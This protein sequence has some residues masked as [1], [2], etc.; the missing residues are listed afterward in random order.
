MTPVPTLDSAFVRDALGESLRAFAGPEA[1]EKSI[2]EMA[3]KLE[4][5]AKVLG[6]SFSSR[7]NGPTR[8]MSRPSVGSAAARWRAAAAPSRRPCASPSPVLLGAP[9][10]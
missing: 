2:S 4:S 6:G 3:A 9:A 1:L 8:R 10:R 7:R 5:A